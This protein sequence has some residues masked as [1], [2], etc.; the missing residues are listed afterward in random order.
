MAFNVRIFGH[1]GTQQLRQVNPTQFT[2]NITETLIQPYDW[3]QILTT[4]GATPVST[5]VVG[6]TLFGFNDPAT[7][8]VI[9]VPDGQLIRYE[10]NTPSRFGAFANNGVITLF[11]TGIAAGA[12]SPSLF[13]KNT[14]E[15][16]AGSTISI[17]E[18]TSFP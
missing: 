17:V 1:R 4:N 2:S 12:N 7:L 6:P 14:F 8:V 11:S 5:I 16:T 3:M 15:W 10:F 9:E 18:A 13:G